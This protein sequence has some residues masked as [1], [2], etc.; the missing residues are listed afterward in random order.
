MVLQTNFAEE[1]HQML[2]KTRTII[3]TLVASVSF[4]VASVAPAVSK[5]EDSSSN[6]VSASMCQSRKDMAQ[7]DIEEAAEAV[8]R[9]DY[10][11]AAFWSESAS[12]DAQEAK[13]WCA[14]AAAES[15]ALTKVVVAPGGA[16]STPPVTMVFHPNK[17]KTSTSTTTVRLG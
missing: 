3:I 6:S 8:G 5:A 12:E 13:K 2:T 11:A 14:E 9:G 1:A 10:E 4:G 17:G 15:H 16:I 7:H